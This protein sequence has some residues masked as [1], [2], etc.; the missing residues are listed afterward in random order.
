MQKKS[1]I[2]IKKLGFTWETQNPFLFCVHH[3]DK[4]PKGN[5]ELGPAV[6]LSGRNIGND[7]TPKDG[8]RMYH[9]DRVPGFP[10]HPH[11]GFETVTIVLNGFIDHADSSGGAGR[12]GNG[13]VQWMTAGKGLQHSE[14]FPLLNKN[15]DNPLELFQVWLN[16]PREKKF[17]EPHYKMLWAE[18][19]P[20][21]ITK[22][23]KGK[24]TD[25]IIIA[26]ELNGMK[27]PTPAPDS[28]AAD[29]ENEVAIWRIKMEAGAIWTM[30]EAS[31]GTDRSLFFFKGEN[32]QIDGE[33]VDSYH[34]V[35]LY[36]NQAPVIKNGPAESHMLLLQGKPIREPVVQ[37][38]PFVMNS[39]AEIQQA[40]IDYQ[41]TQFGQWP[42]SRSDQV[43]ERSKGRF[44]KFADG[45]E[46]TK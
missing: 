31:I 36:P 40:F 39:Q 35:E 2:Q 10:K 15:E 37:Y 41:Q 20:H 25:V 34:A 24:V 3:D 8:W 5:D 9:G 13:D 45:M 29:P 4:F 43:F 21:Y 18:E 12:Y 42:W 22:D 30:P 7:F 32:I 26:G 11:R 38:G 14:M 44:A 23:D 17:V 16:L 1:I 19:I 28:W 6:S 27:P 33:K 46:V